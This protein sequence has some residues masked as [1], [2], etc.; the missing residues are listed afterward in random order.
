MWVRLSCAQR[1]LVWVWARRESL[2]GVN[3]K[4][5]DWGWH[6]TRVLI[7]YEVIKFVFGTVPGKRWVWLPP[8]FF[9]FF[10]L[11]QQ[12][13]W[14]TR[15]DASN[16]QGPGST[17]F[18]L[19]ALRCPV[20][21][22]LPPVFTRENQL[23]NSAR[24]LPLL[25][26]LSSIYR[27][28][29][30]WWWSFWPVWGD[31]TVVLICISLITGNV[32]HLFI[33]VLTCM[34]LE[35]CLFW[36]FSHFFIGLFFW[37]SVLWAAC[38]FCTVGGNVNWYSHYGRQYGDSS[39]NWEVELPYDPAILLLVI[40]PE[41]TKIVKGT[42]TPKFTAALFT[43]A[44]PWKQPRCSSSDEQIKKLV[45]IYNGI[46]LAM[47]RNTFE[48]VIWEGWTWSLLYCVK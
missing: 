31:I 48:S 14:K 17:G 40:Y 46:V 26:T 47:K 43:I 35:K 22:E 37:Y 44:R 13:Y 36:S 30:F 10:Q 6:I 33:C 25:H 9:F 29:I 8:D 28:W 3:W 20:A 45:H 4:E 41:E 23:T 24:G 2:S 34:S 32:E 38:I 18:R 42:C 27:L 1:S 19:W 16:P 12:L 11:G 5:G 21:W 7:S 39:K 15:A